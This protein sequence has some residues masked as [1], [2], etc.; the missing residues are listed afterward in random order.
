[1]AVYASSRM[2]LSLRSLEQDKSRY[3]QR[4]WCVLTSL[5]D[6]HSQFLTVKDNN[7]CIQWGIKVMVV[8]FIDSPPATMQLDLI[9][10]FC[11]PIRTLQELCNAREVQIVTQEV[12]EDYQE[13]GLLAVTSREATDFAEAREWHQRRA[14]SCRPYWLD[15]LALSNLEAAFEQYQKLS[16]QVYC[17]YKEDKVRAL[18]PLIFN[19]P[20]ENEAE[21]FDLVVDSKSKSRRG[22]LSQAAN[23]SRLD[24]T[25]EHCGVSA[26]A[27]LSSK[28]ILAIPA[29][30]NDNS[31]P[32]IP[33]TVVM[34]R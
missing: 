28:Q 9:A 22:M 13:S 16:S 27:E 2:T 23:A 8:D 12:N 6:Q 14:A 5:Y 20:C 18:Y 7:G 31:E 29:A 1:M 15:G 21:M 34:S 32:G 19:T 11:R 24:L 33:G 17:K 3:H 26:P 25:A 4:A 10:F 30:A